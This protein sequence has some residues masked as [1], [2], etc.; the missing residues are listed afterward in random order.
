MAAAAHPHDDASICTKRS[1]CTSYLKLFSHELCFS[2]FPFVAAPSQQH[3]LL[4]LLHSSS[5][6]SRTLLPPLGTNNLA[7][8]TGFLRAFINA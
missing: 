4:H 6:F 8:P 1:P 5:L 2:F 3:L 7:F